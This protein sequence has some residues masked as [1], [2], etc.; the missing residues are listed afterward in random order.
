MHQKLHQQDII[1]LITYVIQK[2]I[3]KY[4]KNLSEGHH[5]LKEWKRLS[6]GYHRRKSGRIE[7]SFQIM[8]KYHSNLI[9][10][11]MWP[12][13]QNPKFCNSGFLTKQRHNGSTSMP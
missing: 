9:R 5:I 3:M 1:S 13:A 12:P 10:T 4:P 6:E 8:I 11:N 2:A 7:H